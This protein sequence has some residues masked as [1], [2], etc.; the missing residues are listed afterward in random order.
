M[1]TLVK[2]ANAYMAFREEGVLEPPYPWREPDQ[3]IVAT[4]SGAALL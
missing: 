3:V 4:P 2:N 1:V